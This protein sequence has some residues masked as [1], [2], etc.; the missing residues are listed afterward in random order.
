MRELLA[1]QRD[2][3]VAIRCTAKTCRSL[4]YVVDATAGPPKTY[5]NKTSSAMPGEDQQLDHASQL[6]L[7]QLAQIVSDGVSGL[8]Y[9][10]YK[11]R[12]ILN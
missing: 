1:D 10:G 8:R 11:S 5:D 2:F 7:D 9:M 4:V 6:A 3:E 12:R